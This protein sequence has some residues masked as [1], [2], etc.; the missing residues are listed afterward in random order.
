[1]GE[2]TCIQVRAKK[3]EGG[4]NGGS[5]GQAWTEHVQ[6]TLKSNSPSLTIAQ[7]QQIHTYS[8]MCMLVHFALNRQYC[9][10]I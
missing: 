1:M 6:G 5:R 2:K 8:F 7:S 4:C 3:K 10:L 9:H